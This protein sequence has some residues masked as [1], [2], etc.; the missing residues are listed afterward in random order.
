MEIPAAL[1]ANVCPDDHASHPSSL[2]R[3]QG[4]PAQQAL[5]DVLPAH[6]LAPPMGA[7]MERGQVL[8]RRLQA[9]AG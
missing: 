3:Q 7:H 2:P 4:R 6:E 8:L 9:R 1:P 5:P